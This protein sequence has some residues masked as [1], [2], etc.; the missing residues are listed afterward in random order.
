MNHN[1]RKMA[2]VKQALAALAG[3]SG[4]HK[5]KIDKSAVFVLSCLSK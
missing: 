1:A 2:A 3:G 4:S 5:D